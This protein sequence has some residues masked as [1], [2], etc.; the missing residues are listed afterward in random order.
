[1]LQVESY[2]APRPV[3]RRPVVTE[4]DVIRIRDGLAVQRPTRLFV[5]AGTLYR[6][7]WTR[8][9]SSHPGGIGEMI[10]VKPDH[11][12]GDDPDDC[13]GEYN[14]HRQVFLPNDNQPDPFYSKRSSHGT[15]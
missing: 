14:A 4:M 15:A 11:E 2:E 13:T 7:P 10:S 12:C 6:P 9:F 8:R 1:M 5:V 3:L